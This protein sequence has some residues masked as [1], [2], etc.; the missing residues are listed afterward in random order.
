MIF[1]HTPPIFDYKALRLMVG[2]IAFILP[3]LVTLVAHAELSSISYSYHTDARD[4]F[5]GLLFV[6]AALM[7]A[8]NGHSTMESLASKGTAVCAVV[9]ALI[10]TASE[11]CA[12]SPGSVIHLGAAIVL[13]LIL[14]YFCFGPFRDNTKG[15]TGKP[16]VRAKLYFLCGCVMIICML[17]GLLG[18]L[19]LSC[20][21][22]FE[23]G[24]LYWVEAIALAAFGVAW[25]VAGKIIPFI[26]DEPDALKLFRH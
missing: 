24:L 12:S 23:S 5:V 16:G 18:K 20:E 19:I 2:V 1:K 17:V 26:V 8:Y 10:P 3:F 13:F 14:A 22:F 25:I 21:T 6:V 11:P 9:V 15:K 7:M 4:Y